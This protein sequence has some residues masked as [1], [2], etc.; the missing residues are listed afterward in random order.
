M[1]YDQRDPMSS[2]RFPSQASIRVRYADTDA[3]G[4]VYYANYLAFFE[5]GRVEYLR[6]AQ[7]DYRAIEVSGYVG[8]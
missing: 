5:L 4:V 1:P 6:T 8:A 3:M 7:A 2:A